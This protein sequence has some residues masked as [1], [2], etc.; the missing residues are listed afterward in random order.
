MVPIEWLGQS[1][2]WRSYLQADLSLDEADYD[3]DAE[4]AYYSEH[5]RPRP[6]TKTPGERIADHDRVL[7][8]L[9]GPADATIE[10]RLFPALVPPAK[11]EDEDFA[12]AR[13]LLGNRVVTSFEE[14]PYREVIERVA[15]RRRL[16]PN[17]TFDLDFADGYR[18]RIEFD[19]APS[20]D[21]SLHH[22]NFAEPLP[23]GT[24]DAH[25][26]LPILRWEEVHALGAG[27]GARERLLLTPTA[28]AT[29][30]DEREAIARWLCEWW[31]AADVISPDV[32]DELA[33]RLL[34]PANVR[35]NVD[36]DG[37]WRNDSEHSHRNPANETWEPEDHARMSNFLRS[38]SSAT[39]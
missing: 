37:Q 30:A 21:H 12:A 28:F 22:P 10:S 19:P 24:R 23:L 15:A 33:T 38:A 16:P 8:R 27:L 31:R 1:A 32:T 26:T 39:R 35:W 20:I 9:F 7:D 13:A 5:G 17:E 34:S 14:Q 6:G 11:F 2:F 4:W 36:A 3:A 25:F 18:W 29:E